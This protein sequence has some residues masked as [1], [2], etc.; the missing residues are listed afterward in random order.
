MGLAELFDAGFS[1]G[2]LNNELEFGI[3]HGKINNILE[4]SKVIHF[5]ER[6]GVSPTKIDH[7]L[8]NG[9]N[10]AL[11]DHHFLGSLPSPI[12]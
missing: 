7:M 12:A 5:F 8:L 2:L 3:A 4:R 10:G 9:D 1:R 11:L 6:L